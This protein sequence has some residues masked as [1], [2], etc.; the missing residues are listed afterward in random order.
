MLGGLKEVG[1][2]KFIVWSKNIVFEK[3]GSLVGGVEK[4]V[5][6]GGF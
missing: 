5:E 1:F 3:V 2:D 4:D 6:L